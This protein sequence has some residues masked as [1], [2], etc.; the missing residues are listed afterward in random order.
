MALKHYL[1]EISDSAQPLKHSGLIQ[2]SS[3]TAEE[4]RIIQDI[5]PR[6]PQDR[7][8][9]LL[10]VMAALADDN[11]DLDF[12]AIFKLALRDQDPQ[13]RERAIGGLWECEERAL[14]SAFLKLLECDPA[15]KVRA[16]TAQALGHFAALAEHQKLLPHD[17]Q[18][19]R[20]ALMAIIHN[21]DESL[22]LRRRALEAVSPLNDEDVIALI[23]SA[24]EHEEPK[25][26]ESALYAMGINASPRWLPT[27][28]RETHNDD[29]AIRYES[30][31]AC[32][33]IG[34][35]V[36]VPHLLPLLHRDEDP[37]VRLSTIQALGAIGGNVAKKA[38]DACLRSPDNAVKEAANRALE[39]LEADEDPL[40]M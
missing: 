13:V 21:P 18:R 16:A 20:R 9:H 10:S 12:T 29:P 36:A 32:G 31:S 30:A 27:L 26:R 33:R 35:E 3:L 39:A 2:L 38:L 40:S 22:L 19:I 1:V 11:I 24:Y 28:I 25:M 23:Q 5:W 6:I 15:E 34:E 17:R 8:H 37:Q 4:L 7:R 14:L